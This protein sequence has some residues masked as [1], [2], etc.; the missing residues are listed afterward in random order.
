MNRKKGGSRLM[1]E[2]FSRIFFFSSRLFRCTEALQS[3]LKFLL[4]WLSSFDHR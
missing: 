3:L 2:R 1:A 4:T